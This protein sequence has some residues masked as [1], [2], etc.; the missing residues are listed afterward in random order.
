MQPDTLQSRTTRTGS[1]Q[2]CSAGRR[3]HR[4]RARTTAR[5]LG[6]TTTRR[7]T[8]PRPSSVTSESPA[9]RSPRRPLA[10]LDSS[11]RVPL[12]PPNS[13]PSHILYAPLDPPHEP[14]T[15]TTDNSL[16]PETTP[17]TPLYSPIGLFPQGG[18]DHYPTPTSVL[19]S[20]AMQAF[21]LTL[22]FPLAPSGPFVLANRSRA[23]QRAT[24]G[25]KL[26]GHHE[27]KCSSSRM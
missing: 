24:K 4:P 15:P 27:L 7:T 9:T 25:T 11:P 20:F 17:F 16:V 22:P 6:A 21:A 14:T 5:P 23:S 12:R 19:C 3:P 26:K 2:T 1:T 8:R 18:F 13:H 10:A